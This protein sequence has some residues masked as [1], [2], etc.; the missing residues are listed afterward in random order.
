MAICSKGA[1]ET[2]PSIPFNGRTRR[3]G[4]CHPDLNYLGQYSNDATDIGRS[5]ASEKDLDEAERVMGLALPPAVGS[6][7]LPL[8]LGKQHRWKSGE[9]VS[10]KP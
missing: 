3:P 9:A 6:F 5:G 1:V 2:R 4:K 8:R 7:A 10:P